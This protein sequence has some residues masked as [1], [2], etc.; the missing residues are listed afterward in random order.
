MLRKRAVDVPGQ[1]SGLPLS[2]FH[3]N[4][5]SPF[6]KNHDSAHHSHDPAQHW[7]R[8][9]KNTESLVGNSGPNYE[10]EESDYPSHFSSPD[11]ADPSH[12]QS[13]FPIPYYK[14][15]KVETI[16]TKEYR[17]YEPQL[18]LAGK[19]DILIPHE[20][21]P[22]YD[23]EENG[24]GSKRLIIKDNTDSEQ[25]E[26]EEHHR[27]IVDAKVKGYNEDE[28]VTVDVSPDLELKEQVKEN[29]LKNLNETDNQI[30]IVIQNNEALPD[31][32]NAPQDDPSYSVTQDI[33][34]YY[35]EY[36]DI[37]Q[38]D[39]YDFL[40]RHQIKKP[41]ETF[42]QTVTPAILYDKDNKTNVP[43]EDIQE[44]VTS[45]TIL[46]TIEI[47][48]ETAI[49]DVE[50]IIQNDPERMKK[51]RRIIIRHKPTTSDIPTSSTQA[52]KEQTQD[53]DE[54]LYVYDDP[55]EEADV[56]I[57]TTSHPYNNKGIIY[58]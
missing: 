54:R 53:D 19:H 18:F 21:V 25:G 1:Y 56:S 16:E 34:S 6:H 42:E 46:T 17:I 26:A 2:P 20:D 10:N 55:T 52:L 32:L 11:Q 5:D 4:H 41:L 35:G 3:D 33:P 36:P 29:S 58:L 45:A 7:T 14:E 48:E 30:K 47:K 9:N 8:E 40:S 13:P 37:N 50:E 51:R 57:Q 38:N 15:G 43:K 39:I 12:F 22:W 23:I 28:N 49:D 31:G 24:D 27:M 44:T